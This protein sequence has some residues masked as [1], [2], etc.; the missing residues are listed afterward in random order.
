MAVRLDQLEQARIAAKP[1][2]SLEVYDLVLRGRRLLSEGTRAGNRE[3]RRILAEAVAKDPGY[4]PAHGGTWPSALFDY[5]INGWTEFPRTP[6]PQAER[7]AHAALAIDPDLA[8]ASRLLGQIFMT[9]RQFD[10]ALAELDRA[11]A[12]NPS[13][14]RSYE[15]AGD[16]LMWSG[17]QPRR[18]QLAGSGAEAQSR[19]SAMV[20]SGSVYY[21]LGRYADAAAA[22]LTRGLPSEPLPADPRHQACRPRRRLCPARRQPLAAAGKGRAGEGRAVLRP[23]PAHQP[24]PLGGRSRAPARRARQG[25]H[26]RLTNFMG[27]A[28]WAC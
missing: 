8:S 7:A 2:G 5:A 12:A 9:R 25:R 17:D 13:D 24:V 19:L 21:L 27:D 6:W 3:A 18:P 15:I 23:R 4:A 10:L 22:M 16:V 20:V 11:L 14:A 28:S 26:R 1:P